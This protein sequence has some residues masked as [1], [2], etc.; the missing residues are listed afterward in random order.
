[1]NP[2]PH[3]MHTVSAFDLTQVRMYKYILLMYVFLLVPLLL[4]SAI[5][6]PQPLYIISDMDLVKEVTVKH[7]DKFTDRLVSS[8]ICTLVLCSRL[9]F[10]STE[11]VPL[12]FRPCV[13]C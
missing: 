12:L 9:I 6:G 10:I 4:C 1:M 2:C 13:V 11:H 3:C 7:F 8:S 5:L